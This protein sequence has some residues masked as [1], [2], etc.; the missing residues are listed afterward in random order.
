MHGRVRWWLPARA[1]RAAAAEVRPSPTLLAAPATTP[2]VTLTAAAATAAAAAATTKATI[3]AATKAAVVAT[4]AAVAATKVAV[5]APFV[6]AAAAAA[7]EVV[8]GVL[9][10]LRERRRRTHVV[11]VAAA[12]AGGAPPVAR[13]EGLWGAYLLGVDADLRLIRVGLRLRRRLTRR[14]RVKVRLRKRMGIGPGPGLEAGAALRLRGGAALLGTVLLQRS[15]RVVACPHVSA[16][17]TLVQS[18]PALLVNGDGQ[19]LGSALPSMRAVALLAPGD[20][21]VTVRLLPK[22]AVR[23]AVEL[24]PLRDRPK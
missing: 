19:I 15:A 10:D 12:A 6:A 17:N 8:L 3:V 14:L 18:L 7:F 13:P 20:G 16:L 23:G 5:V 11:V 21:F 4:K 1:C 2:A 24:A 22:G 9:I